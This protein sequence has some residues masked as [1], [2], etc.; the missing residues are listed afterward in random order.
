MHTP[1]SDTTEPMVVTNENVFDSL[2]RKP[3]KTECGLPLR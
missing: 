2:I 3:E 1:K